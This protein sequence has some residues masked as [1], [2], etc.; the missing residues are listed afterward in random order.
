MSLL[1]PSPQHLVQPEFLMYS[2]SWHKVDPDFGSGGAS[3]LVT[4]TA[5]LKMFEKLLGTSL[6]YFNI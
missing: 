5:Y 2:L 3:L 1:R 4:N 6:Q